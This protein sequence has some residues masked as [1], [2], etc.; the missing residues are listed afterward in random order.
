MF[1]SLSF[2]LPFRKYQGMILEQMQGQSDSKYHIVAPPGSGKTIV[3]LELIRR[4]DAP[5]VVFAPN[6]VIQTQWRE[7]LGLFLP[8]GA[9]LDE[10]VSLEPERLAPINIFT[11]QLISTPGEAQERERALAVEQWVQDLLEEGQVTEAAAARARIET[12]RTNNAFAYR[13]EVARRYLKIKRELLR[14][15][16]ADIEPF[17]HPNARQLVAALVAY[18]V[19]TVVLDECHH[20]LDYWALVLRHLIASIPAPRVVGLTATLPS[21]E[22]EAEYENYTGLLG[23]VD[24]EVPTPA[25]VKEGDL[26][27]Y[28]DLVYFVQP[29]R[30]EL[31]YLRHNQQAF[32]AAIAELTGSAPF[33]Q[34]VAQ[35]VGAQPDLDEFLAQRPLFS[36]AS[37]RFL[38]QTGYAFPE[39]WLLPAESAD[40]P[41]MDDWAVLLER[42]GL[43]VLKMSARPEDHHQLTRLRKIL[44]P[45]GFTLTEKG[46]RQG[47]S[48]GDLVLTFSESKDEAVVRILAEENAAMQERLRAVVVTDFEQMSSGVKSLDGV[49]DGDAGSAL[50]LFRR[51]VE[52]APLEGLAPILVTGSTLMVASAHGPDLLGRFQAYLKEHTLQASLSLRSTAFPSLVEIQGDGPDW[53]PRT[54]VAMA[55]ALFEAGRCH[56]LVGTRGIFGEGWDSPALNTL[57]DLTSVTTS[58]AVQQL[59]GRSLRKDPSWPEKVAHNWDVICVAPEFEKGDGDLKR[60]IQRHGR[61]WGISPKTGRVMKGMAHLDLELAYTLATQPFQKVDYAAFTAQMLAAVQERAAMRQAWGVGK[62]Y[63]NLPGW[64][65][66]LDAP[67]LRIRTL[68]T[69]QNTLWG[70]VRQVTAPLLLGLGYV[71]W[72]QRLGFLGGLLGGPMAALF[73][74][75]SWLLAAGAGVTFVGSARGAY[76]LGRVLVSDQPVDSILADVGRALVASLRRLGLIEQ[77]VL[78]EYVW[79]ERQKDGSCQVSLENASPRDLTT[80]TQAYHEIFGPVR[81]QRYLIHRKEAAQA[82]TVMDAAR[83]RLGRNGPARYTYLPVPAIFGRREQVEA[84][85]KFWQKYVGNA[86]LVFTRSETG[87]QTL[88]EAR[89][90][91]SHEGRGAAFETWY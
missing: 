69:L 78:P 76:R 91:A 72:S 63:E 30:R 32:E 49:L 16:A 4:F 38:R 14:N 53:S 61:Y 47:R 31:D 7:K 85:V 80:F 19:R 71:A 23:P 83:R 70:L 37:L 44:L 18:G 28:R 56:C 65:S 27:P 64:L 60:L 12:M 3:G 34:W 9:A 59:R 81:N 86:E 87:R 39:G 74:P 50:R 62:P 6:T 13:K 21:P 89:A 52:A 57:I 75:V 55:T 1:T 54:Y 88:L 66:R 46:L 20:L 11:Y 90:Q 15:G 25:V 17:L 82:Q 45:F 58:T 24:F 42:Y 51:L 84:Y 67:Q 68:S 41:A 10:W 43:D 8:E 48:S 22:D 29:S 79:V 35:A 33:C 77:R 5:A 73:T 26:A 2:R 36:L 40:P